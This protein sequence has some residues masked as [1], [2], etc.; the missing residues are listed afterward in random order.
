MSNLFWVSFWCRLVLRLEWVLMVVCM[1]GLKKC[2][3]LCFVVLVWYMV[4][5]VCLSSFCM[6]CCVFW[7]SVMLMLGVLCML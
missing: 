1:L 3:V 4:R 7:N 2:W 5:L 6:G